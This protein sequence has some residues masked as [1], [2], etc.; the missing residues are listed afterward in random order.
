MTR[1]AP[2]SFIAVLDMAVAMA[3]LSLAKPVAASAQAAPTTVREPLFG[4]T[5]HFTLPAGFETATRRQNGTH[6]LIEFVPRGETVINWT[7]MVT[8]QAYRGLGQSPLPSAAIAR[9][10][11][12]PAAC[13]HG[14]V[15]RDGGERILANGDKRSIIANGCASLPA[16]A[17]P[18]ALRGAGEQDFILMLRDAET[19]YTLNYAVR[20]A[21]FAGK[22]PPIDPASGETVLRQM[23]GDARLAAP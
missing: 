13:K 9:Q 10:A 6:L 2:I 7:R 3:A 18:K 4:R 20:G 11:F 23:F 12:Y 15:Y 21:T 8:I 17:Y 19:V 16:G 5:L 22:W 1:A 14:P